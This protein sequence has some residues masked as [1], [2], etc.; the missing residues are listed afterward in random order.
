MHP[1]WVAIGQSSARDATLLAKF[2][3][4]DQKMK[5]PFSG[6]CDLRGTMALP[7]ALSSVNLATHL[8]ISLTTPRLFVSFR[9]ASAAKL[10]N[11]QLSSARLWW[12]AYRP[13]LAY[14]F[15]QAQLQAHSAAEG[16][17]QFTRLR[18]AVAFHAASHACDA[19][20]KSQKPALHFARLR[21]STDQ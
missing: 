13:L 9:Q 17:L 8:N 4:R 18:F 21:M 20:L 14:S 7:I 10:A 3:P 2:V 1:R 5:T 16:R 12:L 19:V 6:L 15:L 11:V